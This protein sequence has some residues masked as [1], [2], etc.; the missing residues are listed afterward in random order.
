MRATFYEALEVPSTSET[1]VIRAALRAVL[2]RFWSVPR[3]PSGDTEEAVRFVA[4]GAGTLTNSERRDA[5][6]VAARRGASTNPWRVTNDGVPISEDA[7]VLGASGGQSDASLEIAGT[8]TTEP[9]LIPAVHALTEALPDA[10]DWSAPFAYALCAVVLLAAALVASFALSH[11]LGT[12]AA[13]VIALA[14]VVVGGLLATQTKVVTTELSGFT[15]A[16]LAVTKWRRE[17]S[18][19]VGNPTPQ[20]DTAWIFKLRVMELTR[21]SAGYSSAPHFAIRLLARLADYAIA[22]VLVLAV[23]AL[24]RMAIPEASTVFAWL[25]SPLLL[26]VFVVLLAWPI[27]ASTVAKWRTTPGKF[28]LGVVMALPVTQPDDQTETRS[29]YARRRAGT[30]AREV[31][32]FGVW[33][34]ALVRLSTHLRELRVR[35]GRWEA[36]G[37][38]VTLVRE[39]PLMLRA[40]AITLI[41]ATGIALFAIWAQNGSRLLS[42]A[43]KATN[44][45]SLPSIGE[46]KKGAPAGAIPNSATAAATAPTTAPATVVNPQTPPS[47]A[48]SAETNTIGAATATTTSGATTVATP[49]PSTATAATPSAP[50]APAVTAAVG[51]A[52]T[53]AQAPPKK[54]DV[55][56]TPKPPTIET[57]STVVPK[58][59]ETRFQSELDRQ[60]AAAAERR[61][62]ID[63]AEKRVAAARGSGS[64]A[65]LQAACERWTQDQ[66]GSAEAWRCLGLAKYQSGAGRDALPA[67][68]QSLKLDPN[69]SE[70]EGAILR[71]LR[72]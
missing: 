64:Y 3:D 70:V 56:P 45:L 37:D 36:A 2:R 5:Y 35:E 20:Q 28:L 51:T 6:D 46:S 39:A 71:I 12:G 57:K 30:F 16:R 10:E 59:D 43:A 61:K 50:S 34:L 7:N 62:R 41:F 31:L 14:L 49:S 42:S 11:W 58:T 23:F 65:G 40:A 19:F 47:T 52:V 33:P 63:A 48:P 53:V 68:R 13:V 21:S 25:S 18:V 4:L 44:E 9:R 24:L 15:L 17:T 1:P 72:P 55:A 27:E 22:T 69:D 29:S 67:L 54:A 8:N 60:T 26:P 32:C 38:S 66:P